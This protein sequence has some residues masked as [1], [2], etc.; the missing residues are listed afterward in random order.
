VNARPD[1]FL[2]KAKDGTVELPLLELLEIWGFRART[3]ESVSRLRRDLSAAGLGCEP[4]LAYAAHASIVRVGVALGPSEGTSGASGD[5]GDQ[6]LRLP[7]NPIRV[8]DLPSASRYVERVSPEH[9][10]AQAQSR[11]TANEYSQLAVMSSDREL[12][13]AVSWQSIARARLAKPDVSL[14]HAMIVPA[15]ELRAD[16]ELLKRIG[17]IEEYGF[18]FVRGMDDRIC[19]IVTTADLAFQFR[20]LTTPFFQLGE[21]ERRLRRCINS[22]FSGPELCAATGNRK[23]TSAEGMMFGDYGT[24]LGDEARWARMGWGVDQVDFMD[25]LDRARVVRNKIMHFGEE[26]ATTEQDQLVKCLNF[27]RV[28]DPPT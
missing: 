28:L 12:E 9:N 3:W 23:L 15:P 1:E 4:D 27:M 7:L 21:I 5:P 11:M 14:R 16:E 19:G 6:P 8:R 20:D 10:L 17:L 2:A 26:L 18:T 25:Q 22:V 24:L 13:G